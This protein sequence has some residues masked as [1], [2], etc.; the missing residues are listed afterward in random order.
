MITVSKF[1]MPALLCKFAALHDMDDIHGT[2]MLKVLCDVSRSHQ[3]FSMI[4]GD[5]KVIR[6]HHEQDMEENMSN[7]LVS[8][9]TT[10]GLALISSGPIYLVD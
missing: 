10:A 1:I 6:N 3:P 5:F 7:F 2:L 4:F 9:S 8:T